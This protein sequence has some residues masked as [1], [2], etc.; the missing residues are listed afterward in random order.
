ME[1]GSVLLAF[2]PAAAQGEP[3]NVWW[4]NTPAAKFWAGLPVANGHLAPMVLGRV[5]AETIPINDESLW[6]GSPYDPNNPEPT[7]DPARRFA[8]GFWR[9]SSSRRG[10][11]ARKLLSRPLS[12]QHYCKA[13]GMVKSPWIAP[14]TVAPEG[15]RPGEVADMERRGQ[16]TARIACWRRVFRPPPFH[17]DCALSISLGVANE[18]SGTARGGS[19]HVQFRRLSDQNALK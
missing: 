1:L 2:L 7:F 19:V 11:S 3:A 16:R 10:N 18:R 4:Y 5:R 9:Q 17:V 8:S 14:G 15:R 6:T 12:V 13:P